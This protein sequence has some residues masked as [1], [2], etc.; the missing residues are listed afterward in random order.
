MT[1]GS[2]RPKISAVFN[3]LNEERRLPF[4]LASVRPWVDE[5]VVVDM[6]SDDRTVEIANE[7]GARVFRHDR[8]GYADPARAYAI[9]QAQGD[10]ILIL[11]ADELV[12]ARLAK[13]LIEIAAADR[14]D[15]VRIPMVNHLF[16]AA[17][18]GTGWA[19]HQDTHLRFFRRGSVRATGEIHNYLHVVDEARVLDLE[20]ADGLCLV[21]HNYL[22]VQQFIEKL[23]RYTDVEAAD[24]VT[25]GKR[26]SYFGSMRW[27]AREFLRRYLRQRGYRDGWRGFYLAWLMAGYRL[28]TAA[29]VEQI[30]RA[31]GRAQIEDEYARDAARLL[32][33]YEDFALDR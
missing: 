17:L 5:I 13:R 19:P 29:K 8:L 2:G 22:D 20:A 25:R 7:S 3:T 26:F 24:L 12:P 31:G 33:E 27:S 4:S 10:W 15:V 14:F 21:H 1:D 11:D 18:R 28:I 23:N 6:D 9:G 32:A 30:R 16:G